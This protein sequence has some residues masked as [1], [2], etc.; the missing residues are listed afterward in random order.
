MIKMQKSDTHKDGQNHRSVNISSLQHMAQE[1]EVAY[2]W[3]KPL[4]EF[5]RDKNAGDSQQL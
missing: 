1:N 5:G 4:V 3:W 2:L